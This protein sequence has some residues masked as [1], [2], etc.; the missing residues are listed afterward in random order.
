MIRCVFDLDE[1]ETHS[2]L[3]S[4]FVCVPCVDF[5]RRERMVWSVY[6]SQHPLTE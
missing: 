2:P 4:M 5:V 3:A 6:M 1:L